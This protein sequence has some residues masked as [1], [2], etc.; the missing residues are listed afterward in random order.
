MSARACGQDTSRQSV[1]RGGPENECRST[2]RQA[3]HTLYTYKTH[4]PK[5]IA[6]D[7]QKIR[8]WTARSATKPR[9][10]PSSRELPREFF[11]AL[12][13][14]VDAPGGA[15]YILKNTAGTNGKPNMRQPAPEPPLGAGFF[16]CLHL[17][18]VE[19]PLFTS[20]L[21]A[22]WRAFPF[23]PR[24]DSA[25]GAGYRP[26]PFPAAGCRSPAAEVPSAGFGGWVSADES[27]PPGS[28]IL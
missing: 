8:V 22:L 21:T 26:G 1:R 7:L 19:K 27:P 10:P 4:I 9:R 15:F 5:S 16:V 18:P 11:A 6:V 13:A 14:G 24:A 25:S 12:R 3:A 17:R 23:P 20:R 28:R 2:V